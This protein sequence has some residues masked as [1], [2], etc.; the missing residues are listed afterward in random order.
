[1]NYASDIVL[2][3]MMLQMIYLTSWAYILGWDTD[4]ELVNNWILSFQIA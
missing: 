3:T 2:E 1:M 4:N